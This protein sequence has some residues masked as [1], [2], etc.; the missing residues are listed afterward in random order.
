MCV[1]AAFVC[2]TSREKDGQSNSDESAVASTTVTD[3][4]TSLRS[5]QPTS[6]ACALAS[7]RCISAVLARC[8]SSGSARNL[9]SHQSS[10]RRWAAATALQSLAA[11]ESA[12]GLS[13]YRIGVRRSKV[14]H[15]QK[16]LSSISRSSC[17]AIKHVLVAR[18]GAHSNTDLSPMSSLMRCENLRRAKTV[19]T[20]AYKLPSTVSAPG[21]GGPIKCV[22]SHAGVTCTSSVAVTAGKRY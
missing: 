7:F 19:K 4:Y 11:L 17:C 20:L 12:A 10:A 2:N 3:S 5:T 14:W 1:T 8:S 15:K 6:T 13:W 21:D 16:D 9:Q 22:S 18:T